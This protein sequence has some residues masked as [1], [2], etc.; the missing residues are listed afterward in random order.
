MSPHFSELDPKTDETREI[1]L[2]TIYWLEATDVTEE[3]ISNMATSIAVHGQVEPIVVSARD[4]KGYRGVVGRLRYEGMKKRWRAQPEGKTILARVRTFNDETEIKTWQLVENL[5]RRE[6]TAMQRARQ[7]RELHT[8]L[9]EEHGE[10]A[11]IQTLVTAIEE[12]TGDKESKQTVQHYLS[13][14][15]LQPETQEVL[16]SERMPLRYGLELLRIENPKQQVKA[17]KEIQKSPDRYTNV[18][19]VKWHVE[20]YI[21]EQQREHQ[22]K[23]LQKKAEELR[24]KGK[25]VIIEAPYGTMSFDERQKYTQ[26][27]GELPAECKECPKLGIMLTGNFQQKPVCTD[28]KCAQ[29]REAK[30]RGE[31][32]KQRREDERAIQEE[33]AKVSNMPLDE[34]HWR[35]IVFGLVDSFDLRAC[36]QLKES[37]YASKDDVVWAALNRL[38]SEECQRLLLSKAV[39]EILTGRNWGDDHVKQ[40]TVK[41]FGLTPNLFLKETR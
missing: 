26:I 20:G 21:T 22:R 31:E 1:P 14:T 34:R 28:K 8:L 35:L 30:Q 12:G 41:E 25:S 15:D 3:Q 4:E 32:T 16:T 39:E 38:S 37:R 13:L 18:Q 40:W 6:I 11:T 2:E 23:R 17:A 24:K 36:L 19:A 10:A 5:H 7:Y 33:Q 27:W 9:T 29:D